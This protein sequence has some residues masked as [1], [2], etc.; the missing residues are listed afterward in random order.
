MVDNTANFC[1]F[2]CFELS[3]GNI[4]EEKNQKISF[5]S[6][7]DILVLVKIFIFDQRVRWDCTLPNI[8]AYQVVNLSLP[9]KKGY[10]FIGK[11]SH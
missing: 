8:A 10:N 7:I 2:F 5:E 11:Q 9:L 3:K 1:S 4:F 6:E